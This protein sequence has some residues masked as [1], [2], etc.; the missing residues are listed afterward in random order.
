MNQ[1]G[2][3]TMSWS[4]DANGL[5][6]TVIIRS[7]HLSQRPRQQQAELTSRLK[8]LDPDLKYDST[9]SD[10]SMILVELDKQHALYRPIASQHAN[11]VTSSL[12]ES[13]PSHRRGNLKKVPTRAHSLPNII[14][15]EDQTSSAS[16]IDDQ[17]SASVQVSQ[18]ASSPCP[19]KACRTGTPTDSIPHTSP[20]LNR[21]GYHT[22]PHESHDPS[23]PK[24]GSHICW[25]AVH[26]RQQDK[27]QQTE[28]LVGVKHNATR[29][30]ADSWGRHTNRVTSLLQGTNGN[31]QA[32]E[33][34]LPGQARVSKLEKVTLEQLA[35]AV[36][37][38]SVT[39]KMLHQVVATMLNRGWVR[40]LNR[41]D[42]EN[43]PLNLQ[44]KLQEDAAQRSARVMVQLKHV[45]LKQYCDGEPE[46]RLTSFKVPF[47]VVLYC[48]QSGTPV[49]DPQ[50]WLHTKGNSKLSQALCHTKP[51]EF[52]LRSLTVEVMWPKLSKMRE[53]RSSI[54]SGARGAAV[55]N[56][57]ASYG[58]AKSGSA[59]P[60]RRWALARTKSLVLSGAVSRT[61]SSRSLMA[62]Q[63]GTVEAMRVMQ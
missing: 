11:A 18:R 50:I 60:C 43:A 33:D 62:Q 36:S 59:V 54:C 49:P 51:R 26:T 16:A 35:F 1:L 13:T 21:T 12:L 10:D 29:A 28:K 17:K 57:V 61:T 3:S 52:Q 58:T 47:I 19:V 6:S 5:S 38:E 63:S 37:H 2:A 8:S 4:S 39:S 31:E 56:A 44:L 32:S 48:M 40:D 24:T 45:A 42:V 46:P 55:R 23:W 25:P 22:F 30:G 41:T 7:T 15:L 14:S 20:V 34:Y 27:P 9:D 53:P